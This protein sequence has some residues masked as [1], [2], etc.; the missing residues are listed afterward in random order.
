MLD[1]ISL[2]TKLLSNIS[3]SMVAASQNPVLLIHGI[4]DTGAIF[5]SMAAHLNRKGWDVH[6]I[7]LVPNNGDAPLE[8]LA[9]QVATY[10][11]KRFGD[12][13]FDLVG[14]SMGGLVGRYYLQRLGGIHNV[15]RF[16]TLSSP[17]NGTLTA[18]GY[19]RPAGYQMRINSEFI[20]DLNTDIHT[21][22][23]IN[24]TSVWTPLDAM[25]LPAS[26]S[27]VPVGRLV[28]VWVPLHAWMVSDWRGILAVEAALSEPLGQRS[29][30]AESTL[31]LPTLL[32]L[33]RRAS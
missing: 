23:Q 2:T 32:P 26:S 33:R 25:I 19:L 24:F 15:Q 11:R 21:L 8:D 18:H 1:F 13:P 30:A 3:L 10:A 17:H 22:R 6:T 29:G 27:I 28:K 9:E 4:W 31:P 14:F 12:Q 7:D 20:Q 16:A 5:D